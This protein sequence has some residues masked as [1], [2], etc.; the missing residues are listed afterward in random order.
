V[1]RSRDLVVS[2]LRPATRAGWRLTVDGLHHLPAE[3][4][5]IVAANHV[6]FID[7]IIVPAVVPRGITY[8]GKSEY[9]DSWR[10]RWMFPAFGMIPVD[11]AG[12]GAGDAALEAA[13]AVLARGE[14]FG[15]YPEGTRSRDG[16]L[17]RGHTGVARLAFRTGA[18]VVPVGVRGTRRILPPGARVPRLRLPVEVRFGSPLYP[19]ADGPAATHEE[20]RALTDATMAAIREL[21]GQ[22]YRAD[23]E[24]GAPGSPVAS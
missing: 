7:S 20:V 13:S 3:G 9:L 22:S 8:V 2:L 10:T 21:S 23:Y 24:S 4:P 14:L 5:A 16:M 17:H 1:P 11:R 18:P 6:S 19:L 12:D 15:I